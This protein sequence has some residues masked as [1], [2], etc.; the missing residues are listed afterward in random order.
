MKTGSN[1][2][3]WI[4][5]LIIINGCQTPKIP[6]NFDYGHV[7]KNA[8][9]NDFFGFHLKFP[10]SW[11][12]MDNKEQKVLTDVAT[13]EFFGDDEEMSSI[14]KA[15]EVNIANLVG[16]L[17]YDLDTMVAFNP[18]IQII[19]ENLNNSPLIKSPKDYQKIAKELLDKSSMDIE[20]KTDLTEFTIDGAE[21]CSI[22]FINRYMG[23]EIQQT[24]YCTLLNGFSLNFTISYNN[25]E[26]AEVL[27]K[28][29]EKID[30]K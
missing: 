21:F 9:V 2:I 7:V 15:S 10:D 23:L 16:A 24:Q 22:S 25:E 4:L 30:F 14:L 6:E 11:H 20:Y 8:Y 26:D 13:E 28:M 12:I 3:L 17:K 18:N 5:T 27:K 1:I 19:A 29:I